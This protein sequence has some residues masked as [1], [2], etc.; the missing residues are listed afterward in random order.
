M[1]THEKPHRW[2]FFRAGGF[3]QVQLQTPEDLAALRSLDQKLWATLACPTKNLELDPRMLAYLDGNNDGRIRVPAVLD[4]VDWTLARLADAGLLF[5]DAPLTLAAFKDD[6]IGQRLTVTAQRLLRVLGRDDSQ[7][8]DAADTDD[9]NKLFP[10]GEANGDGLVPEALTDDANLKAAIADI[11]ACLGAETDRSGA[12]AVSEASISAFFAQAQQVYAWEQRAIEASLQPFG[13]ITD[14]A[15]AAISALREKVEDY[16]TRVDMA[17]F[18]PRAA[19]LMNGQESELVRLSSMSLA[20]AGEIATLPLAGVHHGESLPLGKG[21]NP[22]WSGAIHALR[23]HVVQPVLGDVEAITKQQWRSLLAKCND[24]F[25]WQAAKPEVV[26][27]QKLEAARIVWLVEHGIQDKLL[28][29]VAQDKEVAEAADGLVELDK[30][31]R[32]KRGLVT[33]LKNFVSFE[34]FYGRR[35]KAVFQA[36]TLYIDGKSCDLV[37]EIEAVDAHSKVAANSS[38]FLLYCTCTRRG[39][40]IKGRESLNIVAAVTAGSEGELLVGRNGLFYD[41]DGNDWDVTVVKVIPNAI[42]IREAFWSP[43]RRISTLVSEQIQKFAATRDAELV[44]STAASVGSTAAA[45]AAD[46]SA[47]AKTFDIAKFAGIFAA[48]GL[49]V[50]ALGTALATAMAGLLAL[51]WWQLPLVVIGVILAI[52]GPS[53]LMA[54]FKLR[55]RNLGPILDANGWAVNTQAKISIGFGAT[56][57]QL[58]HLPAG[59]ARSLQDPYAQKRRVWPWLLA[60]GIVAGI[61]GCAWYFG[62]IAG[63]AMDPVA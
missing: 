51:H 17:A 58:A 60:L 48:I 11:I 36:G 14:A 30:L 46:A 38:S 29:L 5:S 39:Q 41:R 9:L 55:R 42:S 2:R 20:D 62:W 27:L 12:P 40:P 56:L 53:M 15:I 7:S 22:A 6:A 43:Y 25:A 63:P 37:V 31:L 28:A 61:V 26:I 10:P 21:I 1:M 32:F 35:E 34:N 24:Y 4:A 57:T 47:A 13:E 33:L 23:E 3:D 44:N 50:G 16:F 18:D 52:S 8:L 54:W 49:A 59:S 45:P 19:G